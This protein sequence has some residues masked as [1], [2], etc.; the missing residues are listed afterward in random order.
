[1][2]DATANCPPNVPTIKSLIDVFLLVPNSSVIPA[3]PH[4]GEGKGIQHKMPA[5]RPTLS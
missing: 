2:R 4:S 1:M 5:E 3:E